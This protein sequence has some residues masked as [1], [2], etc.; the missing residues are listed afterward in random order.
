MALRGGVLLR[1]DRMQDLGLHFLNANHCEAI[2]Y[3]D[4][5][6]R[7]D[8]HSA[9]GFGILLPHAAAMQATI[10]FLEPNERGSVSRWILHRHQHH[11]YHDVHLQCVRR[12][13]RFHCWNS[14][15]LPCAKAP[16][17]KAS[18]AGCCRHSE[19]G[20]HVCDIILS[21][22]STGH[23]LTD[24]SASSAVIVRFP[25]VKTFANEDFLCTPSFPPTICTIPVPANPYLLGA[26]YQI[27]IWSC[28]E[29][30][31]GITAGSLATLR[32]LLR[33]WLGSRHEAYP[34][35]GK[36]PR[37]SGSRRAAGSGQRA[38]PLGSLDISNRSELRPD[39]LAA[40]VTN[41]ESH[42]GAGSTWTRSSTPNDSEEGL[43]IEQSPRPLG[44]KMEVGVHQT[45]EVTQSSADGDD[46][47]GSHRYVREHV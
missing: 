19:H 29:A 33:H 37:V 27:A 5:V 12:T 9:C 46:G 7:D 13:V 28:T 45:F 25:F 18:K 4:P 40:I 11:Y 39:K 43:T 41:I 23:L 24:P 6:H 8:P 36:F 44:G 3:L 22:L 38:V 1:V 30:G 10:I 20:L 2:S 15:D 32:P 31:L 26:T 42:G 34:S 17:E 16:H 47:V 21:H 14:A 35:T